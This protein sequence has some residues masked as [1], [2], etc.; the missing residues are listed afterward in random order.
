MNYYVS[1]N[2]GT[3]MI[4]SAATIEEAFKRAE[5]YGALLLDND[6]SRSFIRAEFYDACAVCSGSGRRAFRAS[7]RD[8][9]ACAGE[10]IGKVHFA[11]YFER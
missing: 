9:K 11:G 1:T 10:G 3:G 5:S 6:K 8:C 4:G 7:F 2:R